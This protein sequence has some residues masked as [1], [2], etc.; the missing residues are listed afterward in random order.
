MSLRF[1]L[2][3]NRKFSTFPVLPAKM[4]QQASKNHDYEA[5][6]EALNNLQSNAQYIKLKSA[7]NG[8]YNGD[9]LNQVKKYLN[10]YN[11]KN[12]II[13]CIFPLVHLLISN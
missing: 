8:N 12:L 11:N 13:C 3:G 5:C 9:Q 7:S 2:L 10:R 6:I 4:M 1:F